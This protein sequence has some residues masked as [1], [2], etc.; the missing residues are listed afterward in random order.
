MMRMKRQQ[1]GFACALLAG[2]LAGLQVLCSQAAPRGLPAQE[3]I[4]NFGK[5]SERL[6]RGA[7]PDATGLKN[8][9]R[10]GIRMVVD[11]RL[12]DKHSQAESAAAQANGLTYT[13]IPLSGL[14]RPA[15][16]QVRKVL[17][18]IANGPGPVF[19]HCEH[20]CDRTGTIIACYRLQHDRWSSEAALEEAARYG[21]SKL[22]RG[23]KRYILDFAKA[24]AN[25][26]GSP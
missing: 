4:L 18:L 8:L 23:M 11:L 1:V 10:L 16:E 3:G 19:V 5:V 7:Q 14:G 22:E 25:G 15:D 12:P 21:L 20:G 6:Y 9:Q 17:A 2:L 13:N 24:A 26:K